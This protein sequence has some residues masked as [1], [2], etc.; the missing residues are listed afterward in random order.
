MQ[1]VLTAL[2]AMFILSSAIRVRNVG[3]EVRGYRTRPT[4]TSVAPV[5]PIVEAKKKTFQFTSNRRELLKL[6]AENE[7]PFDQK[8]T[9]NEKAHRYSFDGEEMHYSV[10]GVVKKYFEEFIPE[11]AADRMMKSKNWPRQQY[12]KPTGEVY[13]LEEV[14]TEWELGG[15]EARTLGKHFSFLHYHSSSSSLFFIISI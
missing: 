12:I 2:Y 7:H 3:K 9:F 13:T 14:L 8:V 5:T 4:S 15:V 11:V 1:S 10:T 6:E